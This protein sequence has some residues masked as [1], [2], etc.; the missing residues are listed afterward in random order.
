MGKHRGRVGYWAGLTRFGYEG[1]KKRIK[2]IKLIIFQAG[3]KYTLIRETRDSVNK[4]PVKG[5]NQGS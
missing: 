2:K 1:I 3:I 4:K 5:G